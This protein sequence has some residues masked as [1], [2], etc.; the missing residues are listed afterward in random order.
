M[1]A[2]QGVIDSA[3]NA[4]GTGLDVYN[5]VGGRGRGR[6]KG[7]R[8]GKRLIANSCA[9]TQEAVARARD[10]TGDK[11]NIVVIRAANNYD[12]SSLQGIKVTK[13]VTIKGNKFMVYMFARGAFVNH[14]DGGFENL[15]V[16]GDYTKCGGRL[17]FS[18]LTDEGSSSASSSDEE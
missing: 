8:R 11:Y 18:P 14:G 7:G 13:E 4:V 5:T 16:W 15:A 10:E 1:G 6:G 3:T 2:A 12:C 17:T 9:G